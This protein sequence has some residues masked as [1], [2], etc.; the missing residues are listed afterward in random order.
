MTEHK[1]VVDPKPLDWTASGQKLDLYSESQEAWNASVF[2]K[3]REK[4]E[5]QQG[6]RKKGR[7]D[8]SK[9]SKLDFIALVLT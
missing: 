6:I 8:P 9:F 3:R 1:P 4:A 5:M 7:D 2:R